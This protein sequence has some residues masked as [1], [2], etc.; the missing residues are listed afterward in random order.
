MCSIGEDDF[1]DEGGVHS[2][3]PDVKR[4]ESQSS[5]ETERLCNKCK[6]PGAAYKLA[7]REPECKDCFLNYVRHKFRA[8]LGSSKV[9]PKNANVLLV[10]DGSAQSLVLLDMLH[11]AQ[12]Q[13]TFKRLHCNATVLYIDDYAVNGEDDKDYEKLLR[14]VQ[15]TCGTY[16]HFECFLLPL[17]KADYVK[18]LIFD[19]K[20]L[21]ENYFST[22]A[23]QKLDF[24]GAV[25]CLKSLTSRQDFIKHYRSKIIALAAKHFQCQFA[26]KAD[27]SSDLASD[28]L[29]AIA[30]G[31]GG[32]AALDVALVDNRLDDD[33]KIVRPLKDLTEEEIGLYIKAQNLPLLD[34]RIYGNDC[35]PSASLQNLTK[36]FVKDLQQNYSS[37][38]ST[39]FRTGSKIASQIGDDNNKTEGCCKFCK[40]PLDYQ[41]STTLLAIE[42]SRIVSECGIKTEDD[43]SELSMEAQKHVAGDIE[44]C[45]LTQM[46]HAC[47]NIYADS[48]NNDILLQ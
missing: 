9:L 46:C 16:E 26:F 7:F 40:S 17:V 35:G 11:H 23:K 37:T 31:R 24:K 18:D 38:V 14:D 47:R 33:I 34:H 48:N 43:T 39:V 45:D 21:E 20:L 3:V 27:I 10:F 29:A 6:Q 5:I 12:T 22:V 2:M 8:A 44:G 41:D 28:L 1:G 19:L 32:S 42:F 15:K 36:S 13:N 25:D 30:L 4:D